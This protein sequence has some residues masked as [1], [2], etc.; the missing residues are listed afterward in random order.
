MTAV[1]VLTLVRLWLNT[2]GLVCNRSFGVLPVPVG[3]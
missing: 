3:R 2:E 1:R